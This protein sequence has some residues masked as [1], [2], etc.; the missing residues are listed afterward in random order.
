LIRRR[1]LAVG[2]LLLVVWGVFAAW[3]YQRYLHERELL[4]ESLD[5]QSHSLI[6]A[7]VGGIRSHRRLGRF[8]TMQLQGM[9]DEL[10]R[11][12]D[13]LAVAVLSVDHDMVLS[14]GDSALLKRSAAVRPGEHWEPD[15]FRLV[16]RFHLEPP[17]S[18]PAARGGFG[19][20]PGWGR[21]REAEEGPLA[22][23]GVFLATLVLDRSRHDRLCRGAAWAHGWAAAAGALVLLFVAL[24]WW[25]SVRAVTARGRA[26]VLE[27][28]AR[29]LRELSQAAAG[30]AHETRNPLGLIRGWTQ[31]L[32]QDPP[33]TEHRVEH[34]RSIVEE[35]DRVTARINQFLAFARPHEPD[36]QPVDLDRLVDELAVLLQPD[37]EAKDLALHRDLPAAARIVR[38]DRELLRQALFNLIQNAVQFSPEG[39]EV[40][41]GAVPTTGGTCRIEVSDRGSGVDEG[42]IPTLFTPYFTTRTDGTGLGLAIVQRL[43][44]LHGWTTGYRRREGGGSVFS[45]EGIHV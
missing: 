26:E 28:E 22:T 17:D 41:I 10:V 35:C 23:G 37:L 15:A 19:R 27:A 25:A 14:A 1:T 2:A 32:A 7:L 3:Q 30:L 39:R 12:E 36:P 16:E 11:S 29:H 6:N 45:L 20:G 5:Q 33:S 13:V 44:T 34:A 4:R 8:F 24:A 43:A 21:N 18:A 31:R 9:L 40:S 38:A 42:D